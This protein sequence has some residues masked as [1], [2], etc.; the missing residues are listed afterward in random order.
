MELRS[1]DNSGN[2]LRGLVS[3]DP[4]M[5]SDHTRA[6]RMSEVV[7]GGGEGVIRRG[8]VEVRAFTWHAMGCWNLGE[9]FSNAWGPL[10]RIHHFCGC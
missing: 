4:T 5:L 2:E 7:Y 9:R 6:T 8:S 3:V 1:C 10:A